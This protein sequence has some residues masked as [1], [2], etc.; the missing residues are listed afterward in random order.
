MQNDVLTHLQEELEA[1]QR[2]LDNSPEMRSKPLNELSFKILKE[3]N[4]HGPDSGFR[5]YSRAQDSSINKYPDVN[6]KDIQERLNISK[7]V[8]IEELKILFLKKY[9]DFNLPLTERVQKVLQI[10]AE[11]NLDKEVLKSGLIF[12]NNLEGVNNFRLTERGFLAMMDYSIKEMHILKE[13]LKELNVRNNDQLSELK[14]LDTVRLGAI[15]AI[16]E[17]MKITEN[18]I[19]KFNENIFTIFSI[20]LAIF[21]VIGLNVAS[22]PKIESDFILNVVVINFSICFSLIV[23]FYLMNTLL[24]REKNKTL[25]ILLIAFATAFIFIGLKEII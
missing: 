2:T 18:S 16:D 9:V 3:L 15:E 19:R 12:E 5:I 8:M 25:F 23:L 1:I 21:A 14:Q 24:Y 13:E 20:M 22:I 7:D 6:I 17:K 11:I 10:D 4:N